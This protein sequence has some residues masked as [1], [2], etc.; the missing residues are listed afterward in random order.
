MTTA[1]YPGT[2]DPITLG[3]LDVI[4]RSAK[5]FDKI[6]IIVG[7]NPKKKTLFTVEERV[8][9]INDCITK[10]DNVT[11]TTFKGLTVSYLKEHGAQV[12]VRGLRAISDFEYEFQMA[13]MNKKLYD[14][15]ETVYLMPR[16]IYT[17][18]NSG[19][20]KEISELGGDVSG[21]VPPN[22]EKALSD[23]FPK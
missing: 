17:Y 21:L 8:G 16:E 1:I 5:L 19:I 6:D 7:H 4:Q 12:I 18:L 20:V 14:K 10:M 11:V 9:L 15:C 3:H 22:V 13:L 23:R 2:F